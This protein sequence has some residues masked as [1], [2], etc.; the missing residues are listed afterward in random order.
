MDMMPRLLPNELNEL[1]D[2]D[3][4]FLC[5]SSHWRPKPGDPDPEMPGEKMPVRQWAALRPLLPPQ[6]RLAAYLP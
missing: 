1:I 3:G 4:G 5:L 2:P 6:A